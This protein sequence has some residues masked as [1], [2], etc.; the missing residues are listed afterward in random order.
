[1]TA[2]DKEYFLEIK[3]LVDKYG[4]GSIVS[5]AG[6]VKPADMPAKYAA[7]DISV[8][9]TPTGG[10]DK[11]VLESMASGMPVLTSN[12][13]FKEYFEA[14]EKGLAARLIFRE[15]D[16]EDLAGKVMA[17]F[18]RDKDGIS[19]DVPAL[20]K[21]LRQT[22]KEKADVSALIDRMSRIIVAL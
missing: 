11:V 6:D 13:A 4:L 14:A 15:G 9:L 22:A 17:L 10:L 8:N 2:V 1:M 5:F 19:V 21:A 7:S 18:G 16:A 20:G 12:A 3:A